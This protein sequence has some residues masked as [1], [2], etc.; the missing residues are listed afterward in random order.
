MH[1]AAYYSSL[2]S[3]WV[4]ALVNPAG[5]M[6]VCGNQVDADSYRSIALSIGADASQLVFATDIAAEALA[7]RDA[8]WQALIVQRPGNKPLPSGHGVTVIEL[9]ES[10]LQQ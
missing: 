9:L 3:T 1:R 4:T 10:L 8:G 5:H 2:K 7:A 6:T